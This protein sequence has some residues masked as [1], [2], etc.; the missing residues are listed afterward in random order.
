MNSEVFISSLV[1]RATV[2]TAVVAAKKPPALAQAYRCYYWRLG[3]LDE[4]LA[5]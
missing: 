3:K 1:S 5:S 2:A 4:M